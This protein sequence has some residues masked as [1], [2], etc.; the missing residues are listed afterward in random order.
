[1]LKVELI[2][3]TDSKTYNLYGFIW[4]ETLYAVIG[5]SLNRYIIKDSE[6]I[7]VDED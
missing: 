7:I 5:D 4:K 6:I 3:Q 2:N 1:M